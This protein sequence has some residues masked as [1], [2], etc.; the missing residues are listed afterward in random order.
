MKKSRKLRV[1]FRKNRSKR[2]RIDDWTQRFEEHGFEEE[3]EI[4]VERIGGKSELSRRRTV[5][6][7]WVDSSEEHSFNILPEVN[8]ETILSG[9]VLCVHGA[10]SIV[11]TDEGQIFQCVTRRILKTL[12]TEQRQP[13]V[14]GDRVLIRPAEV[15]VEGINEA[16][17]ER[18]EPRR[19]S[20]SRASKHRKHVIVT[21]VDQILIVASADQ[22]AFKPNLID[23]LLLTAEQNGVKPI[24]CINKIDLIDKAA[25]QPMVG[26]YAQMGYKIIF[27]SAETGFGMERLRRQL[28]N[29]ESVVTGQSGVG[30]SSLLNMIDPA[31]DLRVADLGSTQKGQH[32]TTT[33]ELHHLSFGGFVVDTPGLRQFMLWD[34]IPEEVFGLFRDL[35][36]YENRCRFPDCTHSHEEDCAVK[37]AVAEGRLDL[38]RYESYLAIRYKN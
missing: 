35:R 3:S 29:R 8:C 38:R 37:N 22:P 31:L 16:M 6:G 15:V 28:A 33:A 26:V 17:I 36:P 4:S 9:R 25:L 27:L 10:S 7:Q 14:T 19:G 11:Q 23:R 21:N 2:T 12:S 34:I 30:K 24:I 5:I 18:V 32:T 1:P 20:I 13:V